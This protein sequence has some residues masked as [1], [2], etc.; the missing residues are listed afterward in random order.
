M[1][2]TFDAHTRRT[3]IDEITSIPFLWNTREGA[4]TKSSDRYNIS[5][6]VDVLPH[7]THTVVRC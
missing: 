7:K 3:T 1:G 4:V 5:I 6:H 2:L